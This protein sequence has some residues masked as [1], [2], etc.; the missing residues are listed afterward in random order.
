MLPWSLPNKSLA[1]ETTTCV[2]PRPGSN[3]SCVTTDQRCSESAFEKCTDYWG[4]VSLGER[5]TRTPGMRTPRPDANQV[6]L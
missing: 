3:R 5:T 6:L 1:Q 2:C 4:D